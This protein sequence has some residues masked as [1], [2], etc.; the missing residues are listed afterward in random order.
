MCCV[1]P[2]SISYLSLVLNKWTK[3]LNQAGEE[4]EE[5]YKSDP[6]CYSETTGKTRISRHSA[7]LDI[8]K[9]EI[10]LIVLSLVLPKRQNCILRQIR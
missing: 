6:K 10:G 9:K 3:K 7:V 2:C 8:D 5:Q 4:Q 1:F